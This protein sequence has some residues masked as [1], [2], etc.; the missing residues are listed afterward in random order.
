MG[1]I[2]GK[3]GTAVGDE[4][5]HVKHSDLL[6]QG[7]IEPTT[8]RQGPERVTKRRT[9]IEQIYSALLSQAEVGADLEHFRLVPIPELSH[10]KSWCHFQMHFPSVVDDADI[11]LSADLN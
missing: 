6:S 4:L 8:D 2:L 3:G 7:Q 11:Y 10:S 5:V 1:R 9:H